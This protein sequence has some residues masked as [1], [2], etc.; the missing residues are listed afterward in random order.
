MIF[1]QNKKDS[2]SSDLLSFAIKEFIMSGAKLSPNLLKL[3]N[4]TLF[5]ILI[6]V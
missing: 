6:D 3:K 2:K 4:N 1:K 5:G